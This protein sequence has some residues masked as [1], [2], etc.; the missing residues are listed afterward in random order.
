LH[1]SSLRSEH[2]GEGANHENDLDI[3]SGVYLM[4]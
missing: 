4:A 1:V 3:T 2:R